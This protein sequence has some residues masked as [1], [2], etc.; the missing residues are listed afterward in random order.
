[1]AIIHSLPGF[2]L[3]KL[4]ISNILQK[5]QNRN[6]NK[7]MSLSESNLD[8]QVLPHS[9]VASSTLRWVRSRSH[10]KS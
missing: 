9:D 6:Y 5:L 7:N 1:M 10:L 2:Y 8:R 4:A 3:I